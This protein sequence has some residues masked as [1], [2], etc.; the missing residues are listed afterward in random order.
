MD[1]NVK[2]VFVQMYSVPVDICHIIG[3]CD[4]PHKKVKKR[5]R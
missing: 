2:N 5:G 3:D 1:M 4:R